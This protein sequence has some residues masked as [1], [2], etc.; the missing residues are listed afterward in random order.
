MRPPHVDFKALN[1]MLLPHIE[2]IVR[3]LDSDARRSGTELWFSDPDKGDDRKRDSA[4]INMKTGCWHARA[5]GKKGG[6]V[7]GLV[8]YLKDAISGSQP[9]R[10]RMAGVELPHQRAVHTI[11]P[12][13]VVLQPAMAKRNSQ[14]HL[15]PLPRPSSKGQ[16]SFGVKALGSGAG[17]RRHNLRGLPPVARHRSEGRWPRRAALHSRSRLFPRT[18]P[19]GRPC[20]IGTYPAIL[21]P[22][23]NGPTGELYG[24]LRTWLDPQG[25]GKARIVD[26]ETSE[27]LTAKKLAGRPRAVAFV[28]PT[29]RDA[30]HVR[31]SGGCTV[32]PPGNRAACRC[33]VGVA[34]VW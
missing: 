22:I 6:D 18:T 9:C 30:S 20:K 5:S 11:A 33:D 14:V 24:V 34:S 27:A 28:R 21:A 29:W 23:R 1:A 32:A 4:S 7:I 19:D 3:S 15:A 2:R 26:P 8:A 16:E 25:N 10:R 31:G 12:R 17:N 13:R